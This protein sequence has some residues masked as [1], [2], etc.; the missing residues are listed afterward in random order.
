MIQAI[1]SASQNLPLSARGEL[2]T[3]SPRG[4]VHG[5]KK[6][7][8]QEEVDSG[9][10]PSPIEIAARCAEIRAGWSEQTRISRCGGHGRDLVD[11]IP[12]VRCPLL[13]ELLRTQDRFD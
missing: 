5:S 8:I 6:S 13:G 9:R 11:V 2:L 4:S 1:K 12:T 7:P 3:V 10:D